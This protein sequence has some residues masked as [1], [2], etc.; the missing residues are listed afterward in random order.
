MNVA[1]MQRDAVAKSALEPEGNWRLAEARRAT[2]R[3]AFVA[4]VP[5][6]HHIRE[7]FYKAWL[8]SERDKK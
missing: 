4:S 7:Y 6:V 3:D 1:I 2:Q 5:G 8:D